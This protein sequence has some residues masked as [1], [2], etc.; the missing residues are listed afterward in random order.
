MKDGDK[1]IGSGVLKAEVIRLLD[2][3]HYQEDAI[4]E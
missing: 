2:H 1:E 4:V 3:V